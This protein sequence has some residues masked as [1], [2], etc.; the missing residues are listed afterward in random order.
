M[1]AT[2]YPIIDRDARLKLL[3]ACADDEQRGLV[4]LLYNTGMHPSRFCA[5][6]K[7]GEV[8]NRQGIKVSREGGRHYISWVR[9]KNGKALKLPLPR[10]DAEQIRRFLAMRPKTNKHYN[11][12][13]T[14]IGERAGY[15]GVTCGTMRHTFC[16]RALTPP[17]EGG[18]GL[19]FHEAA[20]IM[21]CTLEV[22]YRNYAQLRMDQIVFPDEQN[23]GASDDPDA[24]GEYLREGGSNA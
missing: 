9:A 19:S 13:L 2:K 14:K 22:L 3:G 7:K 18:L 15:E 10:D 12:V 1:G 6:R 16:I 4:L 5:P 24:E 21:G 11:D 20:A 8:C 17:E 23:I